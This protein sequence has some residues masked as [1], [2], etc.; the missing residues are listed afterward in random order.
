MCS[1]K[2]ST[3]LFV[4]A[5]PPLTNRDNIFIHLLSH[6]A[7]GWVIR[8]CNWVSETLSLKLSLCDVYLLQKWWYCFY[9]FHF[10]N[11]ES[12]QL[13]AS[14]HF[15]ESYWRFESVEVAHIFRVEKTTMM[16]DATSVSR[17]DR[18]ATGHHEKRQ[19]AERTHLIP[20]AAACQLPLLWG[21]WHT[22]GLVIGLGYL[23][24]TWATLGVSFEN[25][26]ELPAKLAF[27]PHSFFYPEHDFFCRM[28]S[29]PK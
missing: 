24:T 22:Y 12:H 15:T 2:F 11:E 5:T 26:K 29:V 9:E 27:S 7:L 14:H 23:H 20:A 1:F 8:N 6:T 25:A 18:P 16:G 21:F 10:A 19:G 17:R 28:E 3:C 13:Q 4:P